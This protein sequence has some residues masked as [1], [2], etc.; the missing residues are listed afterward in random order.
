MA[1][2]IEELYYGN[3]NPKSEVRT[4]TQLCKSR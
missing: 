1:N 3:V 2:F 4:G